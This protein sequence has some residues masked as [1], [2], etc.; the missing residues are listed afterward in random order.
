MASCYPTSEGWA[1]RWALPILQDEGVGGKEGPGVFHQGRLDRLL[2]LEEPVGDP[3]EGVL[4]DREV[5]RGSEDL[6][7][8]GPVSHP[9][10]GGALASGGDEPA[11]HQGAGQG[12]LLGGEAFPGEN[13]GD[14]QLVPGVDPGQFR[15]QG[16][17]LLRLEGVGIQG[18][19]TGGSGR[20]GLLLLP[21]GEIPPEGRLDDGHEL[22]VG[23]EDQP[24]ELRGLGGPGFH[25]L[26]EEGLEL[27]D[28]GLI[29]IEAS[30]GE[31]DA[32]AGSLPGLER[33][34]KLMGKVDLA[35][36]LVGGLAGADEHGSSP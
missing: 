36:L 22:R 7:Q 21:G 23:G 29:E 3:V 13:L 26:P 25:S 24:G 12:L 16:A 27:L 28:A 35:G 15:A 33:L 5:L 6:A 19:P 32:G 8:G 14:A 11:D 1:Q 17:D 34:D 31:E 20:L 18:G 10:V 30:Q 9:A 2:L 4:S